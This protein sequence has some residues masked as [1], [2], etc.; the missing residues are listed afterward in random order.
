MKPPKILITIALLLLP[1]P[2]KG[3]VKVLRGRSDEQE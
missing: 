2:A 1:V 3:I